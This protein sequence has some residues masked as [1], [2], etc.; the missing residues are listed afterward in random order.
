M[1]RQHWWGYGWHSRHSHDPGI[2][3]Q[4]FH[5]ILHPQHGLLDHEILEHQEFPILGI[6]LNC[7]THVSPQKVVSIERKTGTPVNSGWQLD[8]LQ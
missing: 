6:I 4:G 5:W 8:F 7:R 3:V 2:E 1:T